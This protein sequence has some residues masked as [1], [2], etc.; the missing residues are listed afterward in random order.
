MK[1]N[2]NRD[3]TFKPKPL[4]VRCSTLTSANI[5]FFI[6]KT[7]KVNSDVRAELSVAWVLNPLDAP[8]L[9]ARASCFPR[10]QAPTHIVIFHPAQGSYEHVCGGDIGGGTSMKLQ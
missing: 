5:N 2:T 8:P 1:T 3:E 6:S 7:G 9:E 4:H 10:R